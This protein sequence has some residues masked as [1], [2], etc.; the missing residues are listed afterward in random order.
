M[1]DIIFKCPINSVSFGNVSLNIMREMR[2][3]NMNVAHFPIGD[4]DASVYDK[5]SEEDKNWLQECINNRFKRLDKDT[6]TLQLWHLNGS[7]HRI[8]AKHFLLTFYELDSPTLTETKL[9]NIH[10]KVLFSSSHAADAFRSVGCKNVCSIPI[11]FDPDFH[12]TGKTYLKDKIHF[13][14]MG[15]FEKRKHTAKILSLW[16]KKYGNNYDYQLSCCINN[17]FMKPEQV[18]ALIS[19][20]LGGERYGNINF[21]PFL[22][23]NSE[24]NEFINAIDIDLSGLSGGE[25]WNLPAF[26]ATALGKWSIVLNGTSHKDWATESNS[27]L[28]NPNGKVPV[29]DGVF[30]HA[31]GEFNQGQIHTFNDE[32]VLSKM[33][34]AEKLVGTENTAGLSLQQAFSYEKT[35]DYII[36]SMS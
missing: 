2:K 20:A 19:E 1:E 9:V 23:T 27:L 25:G 22:K 31:G 10:D 6:P 32:E 24:V 28:V 3:R 14:L 5:L 18:N 26:N 4:P 34:A 8:T 7:E 36:Q 13:G 29:F 17:G 35:L 15:K 30:F 12:V 16:A 11:G 33:E 21:L